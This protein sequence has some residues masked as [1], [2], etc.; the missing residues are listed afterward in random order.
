MAPATPLGAF[1]FVSL[2][3]IPPSE[4]GLEP[5]PAARS[6]F[7][8]LRTAVEPF[9]ASASASRRVDDLGEVLPESPPGLHLIYLMGHAW[10][11][12]DGLAMAVIEAGENRVISGRELADF[13]GSFSRPEETIVVL[14]SCHAATIRKDLGRYGS[15]LRLLVTASGEEEAA[16]SLPFDRATRL[17]LAL[18]SGLGRAG[19]EA[20]LVRIVAEAAET[21]AGDGV[22]PGQTVDYVLQGSRILLLRAGK[23]S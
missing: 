12:A 21:L 9:L 8:A 1:T 22:L 14:D 23:G 11:T 5:L 4:L 2:A 18:A 6:A 13:L 7:E 19:P 17:A 3:G 16:I 20:D 10:P 15:A